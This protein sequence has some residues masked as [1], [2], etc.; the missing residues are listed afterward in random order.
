MILRCFEICRLV[1]P[2][3]CTHEKHHLEA[4]LLGGC[5][6]AWP[7]ACQVSRPTACLTRSRQECPS[8]VILADWY[9]HTLSVPVRQLKL[10]E[11]R[12]L[13]LCFAEAYLVSSPISFDRNWKINPRLI[14]NGREKMVQG[15]SNNELWCYSRIAKS[16]TCDICLYHNIY[17][18][19]EHRLHERHTHQYAPL[20][21]IYDII[22]H[23]CKHIS[24]K[25]ILSELRGEWS[26]H[27]SLIADLYWNGYRTHRRT[28]DLRGYRERFVPFEGFSNVCK[29]QGSRG[30][31]FYRKRVTRVTIWHHQNSS[32]HA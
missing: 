10:H 1:I 18:C 24:K 32:E 5:L 7:V 27:I 20:K 4:P 6:G 2:L 11:S 28:Q 12:R 30:H 23:F 31:R 9:P 13:G 19:W 15:K 29:L 25:Q 14:K 21:R 8:L 26:E 22:V 16:I 3:D 17:Y